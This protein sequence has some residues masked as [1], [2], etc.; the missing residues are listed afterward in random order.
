MP[1]S[2]YLLVVLKKSQVLDR[3]DAFLARR[4]GG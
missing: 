3:A 2:I 1:T 4:L